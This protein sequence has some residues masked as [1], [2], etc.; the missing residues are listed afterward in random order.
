M[1][2]SLEFEVKG[3]VD[4][5]T[6]VPSLCIKIKADAEIENDGFLAALCGCDWTVPISDGSGQMINTNACGPG[7]GAEINFVRIKFEY[8][9]G[10]TVSMPKL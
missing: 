7:I 2:N 6:D 1:I 9:T 4:S 10:A 5:K 8:D 3:E